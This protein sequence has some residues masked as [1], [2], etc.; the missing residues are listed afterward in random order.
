MIL[1]S[2]IDAKTILP[3]AEQQP[4]AV[5]GKLFDWWARFATGMSVCATIFSLSLSFLASMSRVLNLCAGI[6]THL[7]SCLVKHFFFKENTAI[8]TVHL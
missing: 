1:I 5:V 3:L 7:Y 2:V 4:R 8:N 6:D